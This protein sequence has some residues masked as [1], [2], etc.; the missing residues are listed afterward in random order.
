MSE[1]DYDSDD[2]S[3]IFILEDF[4]TTDLIPNILRLMSKN[5]SIQRYMKWWSHKAG[6][7]ADMLENKPDKEV[8]EANILPIVEIETRA[9]PPF[10]NTQ[11]GNHRIE[12]DTDAIIDNDGNVVRFLKDEVAY[13]KG[14]AITDK[15]GP[16]IQIDVDRYDADLKAFKKDD[17]LV[18]DKH[19]ECVVKSIEGDVIHVQVEKTK[20]VLQI[21]RAQWKRNNNFLYAPDFQPKIS[22]S[23]LLT[24]N[25]TAIGKRSAEF[26]YISVNDLLVFKENCLEEYQNIYYDKDVDRKI[27]DYRVKKNLKKDPESFECNKLNSLNIDYINSKNEA[28]SILALLK[29]IAKKR[30]T[31]IDEDKNKVVQED[32]ENNTSASPNYNFIWDLSQADGLKENVLM[33]PMYLFSV[34]NKV[35]AGRP[36][37]FKLVKASNPSGWEIGE[38]LDLSKKNTSITESDMTYFDE[39]ESYI[40]L[41]KESD[42]NFIRKNRQ[43]HYSLKER[44]GLEYH[45]IK[46]DEMF[47]DVP[48]LDVSNMEEEEYVVEENKLL[49]EI[50]TILNVKKENINMEDMKRLNVISKGEN[51]YLSITVFLMIIAQIYYPLPIF[52]NEEYVIEYP[53]NPQLGVEMQKR[54]KNLES[55]TKIKKRYSK[56][57]SAFK[58]M[59][60]EVNNAKNTHR[61]QFK[62]TN[63]NEWFKVK[64]LDKVSVTRV[65]KDPT[66]KLKGTLDSHITLPSISSEEY[67]HTSRPQTVEALINIIYDSCVYFQKDELFKSLKEFGP[68]EDIINDISKKVKM[69]KD[70]DTKSLE[71][72]ITSDLKS[73]L[74]KIRYGYEIS[75][76][77]EELTDIIQTYYNDD[78]TIGVISNVM[79]TM[80]KSPHYYVFQQ[81]E[82]SY[83]LLYIIESVLKALPETL[84]AYLSKRLDDRIL[85]STQTAEMVRLEYEK[86]REGKKKK[87]MTAFEDMSFE[88]R[89]TKKQLIDLGL[90]QKD[91]I[92]KPTVEEEVDVDEDE[93]D[94]YSV[95]DEDDEELSEDL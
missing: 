17:K 88:E 20:A 26:L 89:K 45:G 91:D 84:R 44:K 18:L 41:F 68:T 74:G 38:K 3:V 12:N 87:L 30:K 40:A 2:E 27:L 51:P 66:L 53:E 63:E 93:E 7:I 64:K 23:T 4:E 10:V 80:L 60:I 28:N 14:H 5:E 16:N 24:S 61:K 43:M 46:D 94:G 72:F 92:L 95:Y 55:A 34:K 86:Q 59:S 42:I 52:S 71:L 78:E 21:D 57:L 54:L 49:D 33:A 56:Y 37:F 50:F 76:D 39:I 11:E 48:D 73:I 69:N 79:D 25:V 62:I 65:V 22:K 75:K 1:W 8:Y 15:S 29:S 77:D 19:T 90:M 6:L 32:E 31:L 47:E 67:V 83:I 82:V 13:V 85:F 81:L 58:W 35:Y 36:E 9:P 70:A